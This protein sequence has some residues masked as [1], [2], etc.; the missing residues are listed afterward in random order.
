MDVH[1]EQKEYA[2]SSA[3][4]WQ[5]VQLPIQELETLPQSQL[6]ETFLPKLKQRITGKKRVWW[7]LQA[8]LDP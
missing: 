7:K 1:T 5:L 6:K 3:C 4:Q 2:N 8:S